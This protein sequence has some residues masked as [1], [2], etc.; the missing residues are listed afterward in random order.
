MAPFPESALDHPNILFTNSPNPNGAENTAAGSGEFT[1][2]R[3]AVTKLAL[4][5]G[6]VRRVVLV[7]QRF[8]PLL[9]LCCLSFVLSD[10]LQHPAT[11]THSLYTSQRDVGVSNPSRS[12]GGW[13]RH[14][15]TV[16]VS[17]R[18]RGPSAQWK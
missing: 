15:C 7:R 16:S 6:R 17:A 18:N 11:S 1:A 4:R 9:T 10:T 8:K 14:I 3:S 5:K 2:V 12:T 13:D